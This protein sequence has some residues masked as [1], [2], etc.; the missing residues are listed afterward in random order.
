M[1]L[2]RKILTVLIN[3]LYIPGLALLY[4]V[5][6]KDVT[7]HIINYINIFVVDKYQLSYTDVFDILVICSIYST[8][9]FF[10]LKFIR[11]IARSD[12]RQLEKENKEL[13]RALELKQKEFDTINS[14]YIN[15]QKETAFL[16][17]NFD[18][19]LKG[20]I[21]V[22]ARNALGFGQTEYEE[23]NNERISFF[24]YNEGS[25]NFTLQVRYSCNALYDKNGKVTYDEKGIIYQ[26]FINDECYDNTFPDMVD[27]E[28]NLSQE[29]IEYHKRN[30][31]LTKDEVLNL[32]MKPRFMYAYAIK[33]ENNMKNIGVIVIESTIPNRYD[34]QHLSKKMEDNRKSFKPFMLYAKRNNCRKDL[35]KEGF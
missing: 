2:F 8:F 31:K 6:H 9:A 33:D 10:T 15:L 25:K 7:E 21:S 14:K 4:I 19:T 23:K 13:K 5:D 17:E 1:E 27:N 20:F 11:F 18:N 30:Y 22:F 35:R 12:I 28:G 34:K 3:I 32:T 16:K 24:T 29:Y 26:A